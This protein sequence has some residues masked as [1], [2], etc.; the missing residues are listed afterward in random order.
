[1]RASRSKREQEKGSKRETDRETVK[2]AG[3]RQKSEERDGQRE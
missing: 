2:K 3:E 1:M